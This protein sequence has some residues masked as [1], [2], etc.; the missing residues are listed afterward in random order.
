MNL[1]QLRH[2]DTLRE[3]LASEYVL[4]TLRSGARRR[5]E[6]WLREDAVLQ[7]AVAEWQD[8]LNPLAEFAPAVAPSAQ[9]W[10]SIEKQLDLRSVRVNQ[11]R[12]SF[13][14]G[15]R[16]DLSFWRGL[17]MASTALATILLTVLLTRLPDTSAPTTSYVATLANDKAQPMMVITGDAKRRRLTVKVIAQQ[18]I[19]ADKS[20]ELW[21]VPKQ[22]APRSLGLVAAD[23]TVT[24][25]LPDNATPESIPV[26]AISLEPKGGSPNPNAPSG[27]VIY[28]GAWLPI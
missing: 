10:Q 16:E 21:A 14:L 23:G 20:L 26:L 24:L 13:W 19:A 8:R 1:Q 28:T 25:P 22:G 2:N 12:R 11:S 4:G 15:L 5:F 27:P 18:A 6:T 17:G 9:V 3:K 7:R